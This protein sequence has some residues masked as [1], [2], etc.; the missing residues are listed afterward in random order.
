MTTQQVLKGCK[1][2]EEG[3]VVYIDVT[4][5]MLPMSRELMFRQSD[6]LLV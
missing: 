1:N 3:A 5:Q 2:D 4:V 6:F